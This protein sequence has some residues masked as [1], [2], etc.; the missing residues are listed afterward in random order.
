MLR[1]TI[2]P[3]ASRSRRPSADQTVYDPR[4][5]RPPLGCRSTRTSAGARRSDEH[6]FSRRSAPA[7]AQRRRGRRAGSGRRERGGRR[8]RRRPRR[9]RSR[10]HLRHEDAQGDAPG[11]G[12]PADRPRAAPRVRDLRG[13]H[14]GGLPGSCRRPAAA[15][16][17]GDLRRREAA[18]VR[19]SPA[20]GGLPPRAEAEQARRREDARLRAGRAGPRRDQAVLR[21]DRRLPVRAVDQRPGVLLPAE[22]GDA[23]SGGRRADRRLAAGRRVDRRPRRAVAGAGAPGRPG[24]AADRVPPLPQLHPR[25]RGDAEGRRVLA[26]P[27]PHLLQD[28]RRADAAAGSAPLLGRPAGAVHGRRPTRHPGTDRAALRRGEAGVPRHL[29]RRRGDQAVGPRA[30][31]HDLGAVEVRVQ[32]HRRRCQGGG[33]PGDRRRQPAGR[34][35]PVLHAA[36]RDP[37][38]RRDPRPAGGRAR[39]G[40]GLRDGRVPRGRARPPDGAVPGRSAERSRNGNVGRVRIAAETAAGLREEA[41]LRLRLRP[42]PRPRQPDEHG[43]GGRTRWSFQRVISPAC[44]RRAGRSSSGRPTS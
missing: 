3:W 16:G 19:A 1:N 15:G 32:P 14:G 9:L 24:D 27:L 37:S 26:V 21:G 28:V 36:R 10:F 22:E 25:Q 2:R 41:G 17:P 20:G 38:R 18:R 6:V 23:V 29:R 30:G 34:P 13:R 44:G 5:I 40:S 12:A 7:E 8:R 31:L 33:L 4:Q 43:D 35:R 11:A 42:V 39:A